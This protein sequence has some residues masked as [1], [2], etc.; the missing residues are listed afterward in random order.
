MMTQIRRV[1]MN[2]TI[3]DVSTALH[4]YVDIS[5]RLDQE[6]INLLDHGANQTDVRQVAI[7]HRETLAGM[8]TL[9]VGMVDMLRVRELRPPALRSDD[10][11]SPV[12]DD[13]GRFSPP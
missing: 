3:A 11:D 6:L 7:A 13:A 2:P 9:I 12:G 5:N 8:L 1:L 10:I 4:E